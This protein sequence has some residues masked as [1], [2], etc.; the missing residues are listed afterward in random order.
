MKI[1]FAGFGEVN[2]PIEII[3][4]KC[5][6]AVE[7]LKREDVEIYPCFPIRDDYEEVDVNKAINYLPKYKRKE[8][9]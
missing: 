3:V 1:A 7:N 2:T 9:L 8:E 5:S 4:D 6:K